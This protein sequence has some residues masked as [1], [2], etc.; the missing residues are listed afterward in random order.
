MVK[1]SP[2]SQHELIVTGM[3][4]CLKVAYPQA[5]LS[6]GTK[7][8]D[9][10][11]KP[12][13]LVDHLAGLRWA[14]EVVNKNRPVEEI[15]TKH[16]KYIEA[17]VQAY[18]ILWQALGPEKPLD[19]TSVIQ[20]MW[21]SDEVVD[22]PRRY[23]LNKLQ[24][25]LVRLGKGHLYVFSVHKP[26]LDLAEHWTL[27]LAMTG[28]D[29]YHFPSDQL[30]PRPVEGTWDFISLPYLIFDEQGRPQCKLGIDRIPP[31]LQP[32]TESFSDGPVF[33]DRLFSE[34]DASM[35]NPGSLLVSVKQGLAQLGERY[36][37][38]KLPETE[39]LAK[40]FEHFQRLITE[41]SRKQSI[42]DVDFLQGVDALDALNAALPPHLQ[43]AFRE[44]IPMT[45]DMLR[46]ILE[47]KC[48]FEE[49]EYLQK[50]LADI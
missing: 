17:G 45:G 6:R 1:G 48:W 32:L 19:D 18:W 10:S 49:D 21:I 42:D 47:L 33:V 37:H 5:Q 36:G 50:L 25:A 24:Q 46:Q 34:L 41:M 22:A 16:R 14:Y 3:G 20:W 12:D 13:I 26:F 27:K 8:S 23:R 35:T 29:V 38:E 31:V 30:G 44:I 7:V 15:E 40:A 11:L 2:D 28:L 9:L 39:E 4:R 43:S